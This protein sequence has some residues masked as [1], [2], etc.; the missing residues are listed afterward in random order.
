MLS[1][2]TVAVPTVFWGKE[3]A[4]LLTAI[5]STQM[6]ELGLSNASK[7]F[8]IK[9]LGEAYTALGCRS[10]ESNRPFLCGPS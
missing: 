10:V 1:M 6:S 9:R 2:T 5:L 4:R 3:P 7:N 8:E